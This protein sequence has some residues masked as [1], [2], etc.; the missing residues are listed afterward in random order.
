MRTRHAF[1]I[2][3]PADPGRLAR[4]PQEPCELTA[5]GFAS[6][7][8]GFETAR[9]ARFHIDDAARALW[10]AS[11][12]G[13]TEERFETLEDVPRGEL[14]QAVIFDNG[15]MHVFPCPVGADGEPVLGDLLCE[16]TLTRA[17]IYAA[18][19]MDDPVPAARFVEGEHRAQVRIKVADEEEFRETFLDGRSCSLSEA[20]MD[21]VIF[22]FEAGEIGA[23]LGGIALRPA[24]AEEWIVEIVAQ[25]IGNRCCPP[26]FRFAV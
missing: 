25:V 3:D 6:A 11:Q 26:T 7:Y 23:D 10:K 24:G 17:G 1:V 20:E 8:D 15:D 13:E 19:G 14:K 4:A 5:D 22:P 21:R 16:L 9:G 2:V 18:S 12:R